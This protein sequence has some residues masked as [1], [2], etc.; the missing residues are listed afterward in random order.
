MEVT[1]SHFEQPTQDTVS[2]SSFK[3]NFKTNSYDSADIIENNIL[4]CVKWFNSKLG[5]G[6]IT[7]ISSSE[8][9]FVHHTSLQSETENFRYLVQG[10]YVQFNLVQTREGSYDKHAVD[11]T[12]VL[13]G[14]LLCDV[15]Q[16]N[17]TKSSTLN[18]NNTREYPNRSYSSDDYGGREDRQ[19]NGRTFPP[20]KKSTYSTNKKR[21]PSPNN[22]APYNPE[23]GFRTPRSAG[24]K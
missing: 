20:H 7:N 11:V 16:S 15:H 19:F 12:G 6:F 4:G 13:K 5:Y 8:D 21:Y 9:I 23:R 10:E 18:N 17:Y 3:K 24:S 22:E 14:R 2:G 1:N